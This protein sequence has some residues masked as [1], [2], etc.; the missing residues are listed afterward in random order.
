MT[1]E[2]DLAVRRDTAGAH[3]ADVVEQ[4]RPA[5]LEPRHALTTTCFVCF[6]TSLCRHSPS[7]KPTIALDLGQERVE[8][9]AGEQRVEPLVRVAPHD[10]AIERTPD[11]WAS[12][13]DQILAAASARPGDRQRR[14]RRKPPRA[15]AR[16]L[17]A[18]CLR[19]G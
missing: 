3:L 13:S 16:R 7:P 14:A 15:R 17:L 12:R 9:A 11:I 6:Q 1:E 2:V 19:Q 18:A 4:R 8:H 10:H 5:N